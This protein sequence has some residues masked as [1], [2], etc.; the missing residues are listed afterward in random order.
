MKSLLYKKI[1]AFT[2]EDSSGNPAACIYLDANQALSDN[3]MQDIAREHSGFVSEVVY[4]MPK[5]KSSYSLKYYSSE[6][7]VDFCGHG[8]IAC[9][10]D[11]I[12]SNDALSNLL[13]VS[14]E[15]PK[16]ILNVYNDL[17]TLDAVF[18]SAPNPEFLTTD[19]DAKMVSEALGITPGSISEKYAIR[20]VNAGLNTLIVPIL[21]LA[22]ELAVWPNEQSLKAFCINHAID[23]ILV[24]TTEVS[25]QQNFV[26]TRVFAPKFGYLED[27]ATGSG[28]SALGYYMLLSEMWDGRPIS[29][30]QNAEPS[31]FNIVLLKAIAGKVLFGGKATVKI[32]G[33]IF[34]K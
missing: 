16:G 25:S 5:G 28:N 30:E 33:N 8:T 10:Y 12:K 24:F 32:E 3:E 22:V 13:E 1:D 15:T 31:A 23:I 17:K 19:V 11:L 29:I 26:R 20:L 4:C 7:E 14:I 21:T 2:T 34:I 18:I 27:R 9:M 6:C